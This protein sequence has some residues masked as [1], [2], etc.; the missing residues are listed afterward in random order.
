MFTAD[1]RDQVRD[2]IIE[3]AKRDPRVTAGAL[4]GSTAAGLGDRWS[5]IDITF[6]IEDGTSLQAVL[7]DWTAQFN[8]ELGARIVNLSVERDVREAL[9]RSE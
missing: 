6:G 7:D 8:S 1:E 9:K 4:I 2:R 3:M 5:D